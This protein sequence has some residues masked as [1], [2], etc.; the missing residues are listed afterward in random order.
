MKITTEIQGLERAQK[1]IARAQ[2][3]G[4]VRRADVVASALSERGIANTLIAKDG[5][6]ETALAKATLDGVREPLN[7]RSEVTIIVQ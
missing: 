3:Y 2:L 5:K 4:K 7:R 1:R 6:G